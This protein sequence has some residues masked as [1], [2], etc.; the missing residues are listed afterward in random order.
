MGGL[1]C[2]AVS[3]LAWPTVRDGASAYLQI[4]DSAAVEAMRF[5]ARPG[6]DDPEQ[7]PDVA[8]EAGLLADLASHAVCSRLAG[9]Y[10]ELQAKPPA[11]NCLREVP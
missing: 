5:L 8:V 7:A 3:S 1:A 4:D 10:D 9:L 11:Q 2:A 6:G